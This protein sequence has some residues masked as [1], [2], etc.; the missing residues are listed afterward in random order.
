MLPALLERAGTVEGAGS[1]T[2]LYAVLVEGDDLNE[3]ISDAARAVLDGHL[4]LSRRLAT[5]GHYPAISVLDSISRVADDVCDAQHESARRLLLRLLSA[6][7]EA[8]ELISIGA[9]VRGSNAATDAAIALRDE[10]D[11]FLQQP[12]TERGAWQPTC[13]TLIELAERARDLIAQG[14]NASRREEPESPNASRPI[15]ER[16]RRS[17]WMSAPWAR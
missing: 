3:P 14:A 13:R 6:H 2:G 4:V 10:L 17:P 9:Y 12:R 5:R 7:A 1:I 15:P 16:A 11:A 8:E